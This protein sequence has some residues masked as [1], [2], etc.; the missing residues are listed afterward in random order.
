MIKQPASLPSVAEN[1][2]YSD[3]F[4]HRK[5]SISKI[6]DQEGRERGHEERGHFLHPDRGSPVSG[7]QAGTAE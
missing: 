1:T 7:D 5:S 6:G 3:G 4:K 2:G